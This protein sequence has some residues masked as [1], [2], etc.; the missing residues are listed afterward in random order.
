MVRHGF[1]MASGAE[2]VA[3]EPEAQGQGSGR[4]AEGLGPSGR[5]SGRSAVPVWDP[6]DW[7][8]HKLME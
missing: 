8:L 6:E 5:G 1:V 3:L 7:D 4:S 2:A